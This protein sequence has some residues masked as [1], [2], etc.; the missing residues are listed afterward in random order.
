MFSSHDGM[1][2]EIS[3]K[4]W[5]FTNMWKLNN[6]SI[7]S[8]GNLRGSYKILWNEWKQVIYQDIM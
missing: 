6:L 8:Q 2:L 1:N 5:E 3:N 7:M 4:A